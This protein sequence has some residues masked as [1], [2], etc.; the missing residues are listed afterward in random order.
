M[1]IKLTQITIAMS[2]HTHTAKVENVYQDPIWLNPAHI[3]KI[4]LQQGRHPDAPDVTVVKWGTGKI[5]GNIHVLETP[6][7]INTLIREIK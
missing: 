7:Q 6:E 3:A 2:G 5:G 4:E 1:L